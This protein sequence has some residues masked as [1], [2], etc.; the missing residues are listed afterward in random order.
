[1]QFFVDGVTIGADTNGG[2]G[3]SV[4]WDTTGSS[5]GDH[6][7]SATATDTIGQTSDDSISVTVENIDEPPGITITA[8][9]D[10]STV[11]GP[12]DVTANASDDVGV[13][14]VEFFVDGVLI[15]TDT[16]GGDGWSMTWDTTGYS[17]DHTVTATATDTGGQATSDSVTVTVDNVQATRVATVNVT[18]MPLF[19][20][21]R[22][23]VATAMVTV[24]ED[25]AVVAGA[26]IEG[27]W[28]GLY[29]GEFSNTT[30]I[31]GF[32]SFE[33]GWIRKAGAVT[34][35]V[36]RVVSPDGQEYILDPTEPSDSTQG[37]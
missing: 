29:K 3:W 33:T 17:D 6:T 26:T 37:P 9:A 4:S 5:D 21:G 22:W 32:I 18:A 23:W 28:S 8:P 35:T 25:D 7:V 31:F 11:S 12:V 30:D 15:G 13:T 2:D 34:F 1:V 20:Y 19:S 24:R 36:T 14:Q 16:N 27:V 10:G